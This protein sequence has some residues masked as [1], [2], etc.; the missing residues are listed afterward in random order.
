MHLFHGH[1]NLINQF[2]EMDWTEEKDEVLGCGTNRFKKAV[3]S[4]VR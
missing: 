2:I 1:V 3:G 4:G